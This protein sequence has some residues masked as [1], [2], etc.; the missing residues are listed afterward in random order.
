MRQRAGDQRIRA[1][2]A[3]LAPT[4]ERR[5]HGKVSRA[6]PGEIVD[7]LGRYS[8]PHVAES[9]LGRL[10]RNGEI[11]RGER[12]AGEHFQQVFRAAMLDALKAV[13][14]GKVVV[15][16]S[17]SSGTAPSAENARRIIAS[18]LDAMGGPNSAAGLVC[19]HVL[20]LESSFLE[21]EKREGWSNARPLDRK[22]SKGALIGALAVLELFFGTKGTKARNA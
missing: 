12:L 15:S 1:A 20:G 8:L 22:V 5:Q 3:L 19:W 9:V 7:E 18:A 6:K 21:F 13:D 2:A 11:T 16:G 4:P 17:Y 14:H 10:E